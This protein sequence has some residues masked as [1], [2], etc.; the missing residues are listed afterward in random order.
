[1]NAPYSQLWDDFVC[2]EGEYNRPWQ[3]GRGALGSYKAC[4]LQGQSLLIALEFLGFSGLF[5]SSL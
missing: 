5:E 2:L 4:V 1:M 3:K